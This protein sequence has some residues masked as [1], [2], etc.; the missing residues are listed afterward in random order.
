MLE[1]QIYVACAVFFV[2][3]DDDDGLWCVGHLLI[4]NGLCVLRVGDRT[5]EFLYH[6]LGVVHVNIA[7]DDDT[8]IC[9][10]IP[11]LVVVAQ[12]LRLEVV[13]HLH[14]SDWVAHAVL[15]S[16]VESRQIA[17][18]HT[19]R[20]TCAQTPLLV[21]HTALLVDLL[22]VESE[23]ISPVTQ[24]EQTRVERLLAGGGHVV[25]VIHRA[26]DA[27]KCVEIAS[28]LHADALAIADEVVALEII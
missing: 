8:L 2:F 21:Y 3:V 20:G 15:R 11:L 23:S 16:W 4:D 14:Q 6:C 25:D 24:D 27:G 28:K 5:E 18:E 17:L 12:L 1:H 26:V 10:V 22:G 13:N 7:H 19:A 9:W